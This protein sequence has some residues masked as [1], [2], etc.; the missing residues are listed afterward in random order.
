FWTIVNVKKVNDVTRLQALVDK[1]KVVIT[2][3][4]IREALRLD[5]AE[6]VECLPNEEIF[7]ELPR[8]GYEKPSTKLTLYKEFFS[9]QWKFLIHTILQCM[10]A[11][12]TSWNEFSSSMAS[13]VICLSSGNKLVAEGDDEM[14][15]EGLHAAGIVAEG[16]VSAAND[17]VPTAAKE[18]SIPSPIPPTPPPQ[19]SHDIPSNSQIAQA[20]EITK[21]KQRVKK[22][23]KRNKVKVLKLRRLKRVGSSQRIDTSDDTI[24]DDVSNQ[25]RM[26]TDMYTDADVVLEEAKDVAADAKVDQDAKVNETADIQERTAESQAKIYKI[27]L[28]NA[29][30]VLSMQEEE[31]KPA[32]LQEV[33]DIVTTAKI[34]TKVVT[35]TSTTITTADVPIP[36]ATTASTLTLTTAPSRRTKGVAIRDP[37]ES[38]TTTSTIIHSEAKYKDKC[39]WILVEESKPLKKQA[40]IKQDEKYARELEAESNRTID[41]DEVIDHVNKK[42]KEVLVVKRWTTSRTKEHIDEEESRALKSI[43]ETPAEKVANRKKLDKEIITFT[44]AQL[45]LLVGKR[46]PLIRF[47]LDQML[48]NVRLEVEEESEVSLESLRLKGKHAKCLML[49]VKDLVLSSQDDVVD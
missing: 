23:E 33:V 48:N 31:S 7:A 38:T 12:R 30:K 4:T 3:A 47:T 24:M 8:M 21:L 6:G 45:S 27:D 40:Q 14:H 29:N 2:E 44:T 25:E 16:D 20:L 17:E 42:A 22:L 49:L 37:E 28:D 5:D 39:K 13:A 41:W 46:Y 1:K 11:K 19:P 32:E 36:A 18:P 43:N 34:I 26:I 15:D 10:S 35:A 9:S